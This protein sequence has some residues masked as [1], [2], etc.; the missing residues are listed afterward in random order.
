M[1]THSVKFLPYDTQIE[2]ADGDTVIRAA[3]EA[4][5]HV[6]ASCG[7]EGVCGKC[8]VLIE[9]GT[10]D[11]GISEQLS[12][13]ERE[14]GHR[15][16]CRAAVKSDLVVRIPV[17]STIDSAVLKMQTAPRRTAHIREMNF[18]EL[19]EKGLFVAPVEKKYLK[20]PGPTA[21][22]NLPDMGRPAWGSLHFQHCG[23]N[24]RFDGNSHGQIAFDHRLAGQ[25]ITFFAVFATQLF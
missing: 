22:D 24:G 10:V 17:E 11:G 13:E 9:E 1:P 7:G 25:T 16:A 3:L 14:K 18:E 15:L 21:Q 23:I 6:N 8:R 19:K 5:V 4:G 20:L 12:D 2:V